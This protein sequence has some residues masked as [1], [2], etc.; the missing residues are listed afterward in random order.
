MHNP[1]VFA[2]FNLP[3]K[4]KPTQFGDNKTKPGGRKVMMPSAA[5]VL[6]RFDGDVKK[7]FFFCLRM[8]SRYPHLLPEY[9]QIVKILYND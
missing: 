8:V 4:K 1:R 6:A 7:A 5:A 2:P 3:A 9:S